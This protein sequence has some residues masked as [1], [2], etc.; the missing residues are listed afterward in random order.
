MR[1]RFA[2]L[3]RPPRRLD[4][5]DVSC[6]A[7]VEQGPIEA[8]VDRQTPLWGSGLKL[9]ARSDIT[10]D[11]RQVEQVD[12]IRLVLGHPGQAGFGKLP[13][14]ASLKGSRPRSFVLSNDAFRSDFRKV[15]AESQPNWCVFDPPVQKDLLVAWRT[16]TYR[17]GQRARFVRMSSEGLGAEVEFYAQD[18]TSPAAVNCCLSPR[19]EEWKARRASMRPSAWR[20]FI[21]LAISTVTE[22]TIPRF[23]GTGVACVSRTGRPFSPAVGNTGRNWPPRRSIGP[24]PWGSFHGVPLRQNVLKLCW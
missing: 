2:D 19:T 23:T 8:L 13:D 15:K 12:S 24:V 10:F 5:V 22:L 11:L 3:Y 4:G 1:W 14:R 6:S 20:S 21:R 17:L 9:P 18:R 16:D 7:P